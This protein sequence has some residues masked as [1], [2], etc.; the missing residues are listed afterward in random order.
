MGLFHEIKP[1]PHPQA[2]KCGWCSGSGFAGE[3]EPT[4][5]GC[6]GVGWIGPGCRVQVVR[7]GGSYQVKL[8]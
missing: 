7:V 3:K 8:A 1:S 4:C 6:K 5:G 2:W